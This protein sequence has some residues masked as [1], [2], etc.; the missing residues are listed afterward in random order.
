MV[1][2]DCMLYKRW[3]RKCEAEMEDVIKVE[4]NS[5]QVKN[6]P[7]HAN[8]SPPV[9]KIPP[10]TYQHYQTPDFFSISVFVKGTSLYSLIQFNLFTSSLKI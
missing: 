4:N 8:P 5:V 9:H 1:G 2:K 6:E 7:I 3:I 10:V